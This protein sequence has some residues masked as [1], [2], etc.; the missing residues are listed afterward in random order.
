M[1][2]DWLDLSR[3]ADSHGYQDD[4]MRN[5]WPYRDWVIHAF[6]GNMPYDQFIRWQLAGDMIL[7]ANPEAHLATAFLR[8]HKYTEE[9]G[10]VPEEYRTDGTQE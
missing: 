6:N 3:Y 2:L 7:P 9:G 10:V 5:T 1:A 8:N 4:G